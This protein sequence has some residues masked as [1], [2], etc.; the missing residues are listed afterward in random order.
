MLQ[1]EAIRSKLIA[2]ETELSLLQAD[3]SMLSVDKDSKALEIESELQV[4]QDFPIS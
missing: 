2:K 1:L 3:I 4:S